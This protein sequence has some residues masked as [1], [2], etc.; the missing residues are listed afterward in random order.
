MNISNKL[1]NALD[2]TILWFF[3]WILSLYV[4]DIFVL[5]FDELKDNFTSPEYDKGFLNGAGLASSV[6]HHSHIAY[7][8]AKTGTFDGYGFQRFVQSKETKFHYHG[9]WN[10]VSLV[11]AGFRVRIN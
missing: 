10:H 11:S 6:L 2:K 7:N 3:G 8:L 1:Y 5:T 9:Y 4:N